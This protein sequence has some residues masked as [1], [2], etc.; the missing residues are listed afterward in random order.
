MNEDTKVIIESIIDNS[1]TIIVLFVSIFGLISLGK[2]KDFKHTRIRALFAIAL[3]SILL[4]RVLEFLMTMTDSFA[5]ELIKDT[6]ELIFLVCIALGIYF[7]NS[8]NSKQIR[9]LGTAANI[10]NL[11]GLFNYGY[12]I[13][14]AK[15][16][17]IGMKNTNSPGSFL[18]LDIDKFKSYNDTYGHEAGNIVLKQVAECLKDSLRPDDLAARYGGEEFVVLVHEESKTAITIAERINKKVENTCNPDHNDQVKRS[19][20]VSIGVANMTENHSN[21]NDIIKEADQH[22]YQAKMNG[23]NQVF[24]VS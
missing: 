22:M 19:I 15:N 2:I 17:F 18:F 12:F 23:R 7:W 16:H 3:T 5:I 4:E 14:E 13:K 21:L 9:S 11:T 24:S 20:T 10:D 6:V 8:A 1:T